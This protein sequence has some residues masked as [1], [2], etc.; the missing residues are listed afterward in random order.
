MTKAEV[1]ALLRLLAEWE[2]SDTELQCRLHVGPDDPARYLRTEVYKR[3]AGISASRWK[4][5]SIH[6]AQ[7]HGD[8]VN[9]LHRHSLTA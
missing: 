8:P 5:G 6:P 2:R 9:Y 3:G 4:L 7:S 1:E